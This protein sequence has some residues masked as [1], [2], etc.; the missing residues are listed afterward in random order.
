[1]TNKNISIGAGALMTI[2]LFLPF[3]S[4]GGLSISLF[5]GVT[6]APDA[7]GVIVLLAAVGALVT[8]FLDKPGIARLC[9]G[10]VLAACLYLIYNASQIPGAG[11]FMGLIG[12]GAYALFAGSIVG[13]LFS[14]K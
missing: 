10:V 4:M 11:D 7:E 3:M 8:A 5:D 2:S 6:T 1:M 12:L 9:S 14:K 13:V